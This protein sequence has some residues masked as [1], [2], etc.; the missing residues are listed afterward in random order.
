MGLFFLHPDTEAGIAEP[1]VAFQRVAVALRAEH[2]DALREARA[3][4]ITPEFR[5]KARFP[6]WGECGEVWLASAWRYRL[7]CGDASS[8]SGNHASASCRSIGACAW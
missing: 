2:Y 4:R 5:S 1:A 3:G 8:S 6:T 7:A